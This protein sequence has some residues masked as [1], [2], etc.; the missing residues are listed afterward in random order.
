MG[1][2]SPQGRF[3]SILSQIAKL[4]NFETAGNCATRNL[5]RWFK[6]W[7]GGSFQQC[8]TPCATASTP[9][10]P[11]S[12]NCVTANNVRSISL[13]E[14]GVLLLEGRARGA[15]SAAQS[16]L[17][18]VQALEYSVYDPR[19]PTLAHRCMVSTLDRSN[20]TTKLGP[21]SVYEHTRAIRWTQIQTRIRSTSDPVSCP[22]GD[23][24]DG[25]AGSCP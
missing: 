3:H 16:R 25:G 20:D 1:S 8:Q 11:S 10:P 7:M 14:L 18:R 24:N 6:P 22:H 4:G 12:P 17:W 23:S 21:E 15:P 2:A 5:T 13:P 19:R 9:R